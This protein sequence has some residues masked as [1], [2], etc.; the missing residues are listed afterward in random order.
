MKLY[1]AFAEPG[2]HTTISTTF[3]IDFV[4]YEQLTLARLREAG[5]MNNIVVADARMLTYALEDAERPP[6][7][8]GRRYIVICNLK[9]APESQPHSALGMVTSF[10][11][12]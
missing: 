11:V 3:A 10:D 2:F 9:D 6:L 5:C 1:N 8:A 4:A 12:P 7:Q